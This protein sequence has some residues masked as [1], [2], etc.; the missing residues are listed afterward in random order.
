[1]PAP[2]CPCGRLSSRRQPLAWLDCCGRY[3]DA[4]DTLPAPD[5]ESLMRSRYSAFVLQRADYLLATWHPSTRPSTLD[6]EPGVRWL[7]LQVRG[8]WPAG[9][10][11]E[12]EFVAR[13]REAGRAVRLHERSRFVR[14]SWPGLGVNAPAALRWFY[15][16]GRF[17]G[18]SG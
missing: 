18:Q 17:P 5:A 8:H 3:L 14:E 13:F 12:V 7:G 2:S 9:D 11:A 1:M 6:L 16:D 10:R 4:F 15:V